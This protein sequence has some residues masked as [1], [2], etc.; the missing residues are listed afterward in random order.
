[1]VD[2]VL[3]RE[4][5]WMGFNLHVRIDPRDRPLST[6]NF[7]RADLGGVVDDLALQ[8]VERN[9]IVVDDAYGSDAGR[10]QVEDDRRAEPSGANDQDTRVFEL[11]LPLSA[12]FSQHKVALVALDLFGRQFC[13][14]FALARAAITNWTAQR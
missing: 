10:C 13:H 3:R 1:D 14:L 9:D 12:H 4:A 6:F 8:V 7:R 2:R 5:D 11:L